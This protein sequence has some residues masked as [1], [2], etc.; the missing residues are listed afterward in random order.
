MK[1][2]STFEQFR[3]KRTEM[4]TIIDQEIIDSKVQLQLLRLKLSE[5]RKDFKEKKN[6]NNKHLVEDKSIQTIGHED[7]SVQVDQNDF[8]AVAVEEKT[9]EFVPIQRHNRSKTTTKIKNDQRK[10]TNTMMIQQHQTKPKMLVIND[11]YEQYL[12][13][14]NRMKQQQKQQAMTTTTENNQTKLN[15]IDNDKQQQATTTTKIT[16][17]VAVDTMSPPSV[18]D[19]IPFSD[20]TVYLDLPPESKRIRKQRRPIAKANDDVEKL[21]DH[22]RQSLTTTDDDSNHNQDVDQEEMNADD[23]N[24]SSLFRTLLQSSSS[25]ST[26]S[27][28]KKQTTKP[29]DASI[30]AIIDDDKDDDNNQLSMTNITLPSMLNNLTNQ[31]LLLIDDDDHDDSIDYEKFWKDVFTKAGLKK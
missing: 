25:T 6:T 15:K 17:S 2:S 21:T 7:R 9:E 14:I 23:D 12:E 5:Y 27:N 20:Q 28:E 3:S 4:I 29:D 22:L 16:R 13:R 10:S 19:L 1:M 30:N 24:T 8:V 31:T 18:F 11:R 26:K